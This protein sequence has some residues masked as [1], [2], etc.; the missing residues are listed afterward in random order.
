MGSE[1]D[2]VVHVDGISQRRMGRRKPRRTSHGAA[3]KAPS[4]AKEVEGGRSEE[5]E[6]VGGTH[7]AYEDV[8]RQKETLQRRVLELEETNADLKGEAED[9]RYWKA[10][11]HQI[12]DEHMELRRE[13]EA[14]REKKTHP[15]NKEETFRVRMEKAERA[16]ER[17]RD[18]V[19]SLQK[20]IEAMEEQFRYVDATKQ[21]SATN[22]DRIRRLEEE[23]DGAKTKLKQEQ[24]NN[25]SLGLQIMDMESQ[26]TVSG[27]DAQGISRELERLRQEYA[28]AQADAAAAKMAS[29]EAD[30]AW[31]R[32]KDELIELQQERENLTAKIESVQETMVKLLQLNDEL[33]EQ[34]NRKQ[35]D[36]DELVNHLAQISQDDLELGVEEARSP[37]ESEE[38][39]SVIQQADGQDREAAQAQVV[40][41]ED[42]SDALESHGYAEPSPRVETQE[43][44]NENGP[45]TSV[46]VVAEPP[47]RLVMDRGSDSEVQLG[48]S[49]QKTGLWSYITGADRIDVDL[50]K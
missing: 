9:A 46:P 17:E 11:L 43:A 8:Q 1:W 37:A 22:E 48:R 35:Y 5:E 25:A 4:D 40:G 41:I 21:R 7:D 42:Q 10:A 28:Q 13:I 47:D 16:L 2:G 29:A 32:T 20:K 27:I 30:E 3:S 49:P 6:E 34:V 12:Q 39:E 31:K 50:N 24:E 44:G 14:L 23:L 36:I 15:G 26:R 19:K 33:T 45:F 18:M 38:E